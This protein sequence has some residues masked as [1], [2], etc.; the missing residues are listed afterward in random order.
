MRLSLVPKEHD[1]F[2][3]FSELAANLDAAAQLLV[4][5]MT[6]GDRKNIAAAILEHEHVGD[7]IVHDVIRRLN[8]SFITPIDREDIYDLVSTTDEVLDNIEAAVD[9]VLLYRVGEITPQAKRQAEVIAKAT[10]LLRECMD[11]LEKPK[12]M[13]A[14]IIAINSLENDGDR[15]HRDA[16][17]SLF[18]GGMS[19]TDIIKWKD[20]YENLEAAIDECEHVANVIESIVLK[21]N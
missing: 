16:M 20:I 5:F 12:D 17:A 3:L 7:K 9:M 2:R 15:I 6:D 13:D 11:N 8:K 21:H 18:D 1:Y 4:R 14:R 10:P 19:C